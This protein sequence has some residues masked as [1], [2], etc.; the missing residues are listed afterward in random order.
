M[1]PFDLLLAAHCAPTLAGIKPANLVSCQRSRFPQLPRQLET[2]GRAFAPKDV[3]FQILC[4]CPGRY[5]LLVY[6]RVLL[7]HCLAQPEAARL[8]EQF[9]YCRDEPLEAKLERLGR[10]AAGQE[11]FPHE[12]G[13]FLGYPPEDVEGFIRYGGEDC[14]LCGCWKV[15]GDVEQASRQFA[16]ISQVCRACVRRVEQGE[17]LFEV[18]AVA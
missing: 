8:L 17:T 7:E 5:L 4:T 9:G 1:I 3:H 18:F 14:K 16:R 13:L 15:Y 12:I 11:G 6:R 2:Y 10:R